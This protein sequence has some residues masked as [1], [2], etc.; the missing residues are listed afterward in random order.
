M[1][2]SEETVEKEEVPVD[3]VVETETTLLSEVEQLRADLE[4]QKKVGQEAQDQYLRTLAEHEN[5]K[6]RT[7]KD[8]SEQIK[9]ANE[10]LLKEVLPI[11]DNLERAISHSSETSDFKLMLEGV[12][13]VKK[14]LLSVLDKFGVR[15]I[16]C[17][18]Q[19]FD[20]FCHQS[21]GLVEVEADAEIEDN[22]V[23]EEAQKGYLLNDRV[24]RPSFVILAKKKQAEV[25]DDSASS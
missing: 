6:K 11:V 15:P 4:A 17:L 12:A 22:H 10:R 21:V 24:L 18:N 23:M 1:T 13:L 14:Q 19:A 9:F 7:Q 8:K 16:E 25:S 5:Y 20:P 2:E 3:D